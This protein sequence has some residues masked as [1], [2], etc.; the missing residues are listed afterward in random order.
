MTESEFNDLVDDILISIEDQLDEYES[1]ID[2][3]T[4]TGILTLSMPNSSQIIINRQRPT[5]QLW[6]AAKSGGFHF[7]YNNETGDWL[8]TRRGDKFFDSLNRCLQEQ[9]GETFNLS[10]D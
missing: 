6:L 7:E 2:C 4:S 9:T 5:Q 1:D 8:D 10:Y 3:E